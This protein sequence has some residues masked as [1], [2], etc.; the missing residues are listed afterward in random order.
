M[1]SEKEI[2]KKLLKPLK[3]ERNLGYTNSAV[4][5]G[6]ASYILNW[7]GSLA[8][9]TTKEQLLELIAEL[10]QLFSDYA[11][12]APAQRKEKLQESRELFSRLKEVAVEEVQSPAEAAAV[13]ESGPEY[14]TAVQTEVKEEEFPQFWRQSIRYIKGVGKKRA[15][16]LSRLGI[17]TVWDALFYFPRDYRDWSQTAQIKDLKVGSKVTVRGQ[18][19]GTEELRPRQGLTIIKVIIGDGTGKL[20]GV[21]FNQPYLK[22]NFKRG[23]Q[24]AFSG[25]IQR[26]Y[27]ELQINNPNYELFKS[28]DDIY[29]G[30]ILP[31]YAATEGI[32][33]NFLR[34]LI[35]RLL[36][37]ELAKLPEFLPLELR[38][39]HRLWGIKEALEQIHFPESREELEQARRRL[40]FDELLILQLGVLLKKS[41]LGEVESGVLHQ[42]KQ[43]L[44]AQ[45]R[46]QLPFELTKAQLKVW[47]EIKE[48]MESAQVMNRLIQGDV[49]SGKTVVATLALLKAV[50]S[51]YQGA[52][53]APTE[54][55]AEQ[56]YLG[57]EDSLAD[58]DLELG[59][60]VGS[61]RSSAKEE[62]L[63][64]IAQGEIDIVIGT[65]ALIQEGIEFQKLG[66]VITD[67]Q[68]R[69]GVKQ[70]AV[71]KEKGANPDV[72]VMTATPI[73]RTLALTL[74]GDLDLSVIDELP[75]GRKPVVTEWRSEAAYPKIYSF[76]RQQIEAGRQAYV[77]CP[78][79]EESEELDITSAVELANQLNE[80][81]FPQL[82]IGLLHGQLKAEQ[83]EMIMEKFR[84][85]EIDILV[86]TTVIEVGVNVPNATLMLIVDAQRF[87][88]A[89]LHQLRGRVGRGEHQSYCV[90]VADPS[91]DSGRQRMRIMTRSN[92]GFEIAEEDLKLRGPGEFFGTRQH[93]LPDL[94][95]ANLLRDADTLE[96]ARKEA[97][98]MLESDNKLLAA[99]HQLLKRLIEIRFGGSIEMI[100]VS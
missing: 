4:L 66:L 28:K 43:Q 52:M 9:L 3:I 21:W 31:V 85:G 29:V 38:S 90:L 68:H 75:P 49:G 87:G 26:K 59:L 23:A 97:L 69:F 73:P 45:Y 72:L 77:V 20:A 88:L 91:T 19:L 15:A 51:G 60:L 64:E 83:K 71:L 96:L 98:Q 81:V 41:D 18:V 37:E 22:K 99:E 50:G 79:V 62:L 44:A 32:S 30:R 61:L 84:C 7:L 8:E 17:E 57:L 70:R 16:K 54:I 42:E 100:E 12:V 63:T 40:V 6:F 55:L 48:D 67:E 11:Q 92:D 47:E 36:K 93:G 74:Y 10:E 82:T 2:I 56:H 58:Y 78:L 1:E 14:Q 95:I 33:Q 80:E 24:V 25:E 35:K 13:Q 46:Q 34:K 76:M 27:G 5:G 94:K 89:Q 39:K 53:M 65:H 86:S